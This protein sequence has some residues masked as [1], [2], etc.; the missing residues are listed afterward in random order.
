MGCDIHMYAEALRD[1][2]WYDLGEIDVGRSYWLFGILAGVR[3]PVDQPIAAARGLPAGCVHLDPRD[4]SYDRTWGGDPDTWLGEHSFSWCWLSELLAYPWEADAAQRFPG[5]DV[6]WVRAL[7]A[8]IT[9]PPDT[10]RL[11]FGFDN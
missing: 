6:S 3:H 9:D 2:A 7:F 8:H 1:G 10:V 4:G 11:V 5:H